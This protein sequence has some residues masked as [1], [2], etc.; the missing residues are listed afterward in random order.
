MRLP[1]TR[2][3]SRIYDLSRGRIWIGVLIIVLI[4]PLWTARLKG[5][6]A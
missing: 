5:L 1:G 4:V 2:C 3:K 6:L